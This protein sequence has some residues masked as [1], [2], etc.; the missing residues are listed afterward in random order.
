[1][2]Q[3]LPGLSE[4]NARPPKWNAQHVFRQLLVRKSAKVTIEE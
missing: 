4:G 2:N 3:R 1:M